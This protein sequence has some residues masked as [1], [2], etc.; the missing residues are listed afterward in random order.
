M[1]L[2]KVVPCKKWGDLERPKL[3]NYKYL[4]NIIRELSVQSSA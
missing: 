2:F 4:L 3:E 1:V